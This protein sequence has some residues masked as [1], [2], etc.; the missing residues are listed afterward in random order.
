MSRRNLDEAARRALGI[1]LKMLREERG[2]S[3]QEVA[4]RLGLGRGTTL[5]GYEQGRTEPP[6]VVLIQLA[7]LYKSRV[8]LT[9]LHSDGVM[10]HEILE[11]PELVRILREVRRLHRTARRGQRRREW[12]TLMALLALE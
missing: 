2:W 6:L 8:D 5:A 3:Q 1:Q 9:A 11:D 12:R 7:H 10:P 4:A